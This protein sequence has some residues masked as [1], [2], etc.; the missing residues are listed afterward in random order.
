VSPDSETLILSLIKKNADSM[1]VKNV[2]KISPVDYVQNIYLSVMI[3]LYKA[4]SVPGILHLKYPE[5]YSTSDLDEL[6]IDK[7]LE[8]SASDLRSFRTQCANE[9]SSES[10]DARLS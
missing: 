7:I 6:D 4:Q 9:E 8:Y 1:T 5:L 2:D 3:Q 10:R